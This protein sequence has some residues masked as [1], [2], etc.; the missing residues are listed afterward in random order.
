MEE[1]TRE[2]HKRMV[3]SERDESEKESNRAKGQRRKE[4]LRKKLA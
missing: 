1:K 3:I 4:I 2:K